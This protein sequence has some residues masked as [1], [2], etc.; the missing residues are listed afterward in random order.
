MTNVLHQP[1]LTGDLIVHALSRDLDRPVLVGVD[2]EVITAGG[3]RDAIS[4]FQQV[5]ENLTPTPTRAAVLARNRLEVLYATNGLSFAGVVLTTLHPMGSMEDY[6]YIIDDASIDTLVYDADHYEDIAAG[7]KERAPLLKHFIAMGQGKVGQNII[8]ASLAYE[9]KPLVARRAEPHE[10]AR[11]AYSGG[12][13]GKPK[14]I[15]CSHLCSV[16]SAMIQLME[17]EWPQEIR[18]LVC[19]PLSHSGA[20]VLTSVLARKAACMCCPAL[21]R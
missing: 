15:M 12:T 4:R 13:T 8:A 7:L 5:I 21:I 2:G 18:H 17:W 3:L 19:A 9:S 14:G 16:T 20:A 11:I 10:L 6:L 1:I